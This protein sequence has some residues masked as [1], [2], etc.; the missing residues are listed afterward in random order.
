M[1]APAPPRDRGP[2][3]LVH[4]IW[5]VGAEM[6]WLARSLQRAGFGPVRQFHYPSVRHGLADNARRLAEFRARFERRHGPAHLVGHSLGGVVLWRMFHDFGATTT[7]AAAASAAVTTGGTPVR[8]VALGAPFQGSATARFFTRR[9]NPL[10]RALVGACWREEADHSPAAGRTWPGPT[11]LGIL[12]GRVPI[13]VGALIGALPAPNDGVVALAETPLSGATDYRVLDVAHVAL[14]FAPAAVRQ[15]THFLAH[16]CF[17][18]KEDLV[19][20]AGTTPAASA[21]TNTSEAVSRR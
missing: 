13:G 8:V 12:A 16:G 17:G 6:L 19:S 14:T 20:A 18:R 11:P 4:G 2:V 3:I 5:M 9:G 1:P 10:G 7:T 15:T 21:A